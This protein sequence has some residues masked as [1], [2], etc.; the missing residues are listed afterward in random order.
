MWTAPY[1]PTNPR[2]FVRFGRTKGEIWVE[3]GD[4]QGDMGFLRG[5]DLVGESAT[6]PTYIWEIFFFFW[7]GG[8]PYEFITQ[9]GDSQKFITKFVTNFITKNLGLI[10]QFPSF[11]MEKSWSAIPTLCNAVSPYLSLASTFA[12]AR[13]NVFTTS[14]FPA[15]NTKIQKQILFSCPEQLN[16]WP[17]HWLTHSVTVLLLLTHK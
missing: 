15:W 7:G 8:S 12:L 11:E 5:L 17:C 14:R 2:V 6:P 4:F 16:R 13:N 1:P 10:H 9:F 3:K